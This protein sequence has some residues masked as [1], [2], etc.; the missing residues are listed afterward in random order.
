MTPDH[1]TQTR[2][3][4][5]NAIPL[6]RDVEG[7]VPNQSQVSAELTT[8]VP[9]VTISAPCDAGAR[10]SPAKRISVYGAPTIVASTMARRQPIPAAFLTP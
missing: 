8:G 5:I 3:A 7:R 10:A 4:R 1:V 2:P 6:V 9:P